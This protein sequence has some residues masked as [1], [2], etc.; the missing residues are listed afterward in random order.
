MTIQLHY[1][2]NDDNESGITMK[3][4]KEPKQYQ[5]MYQF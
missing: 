2:D 5:Y 3:H 4:Y 1:N